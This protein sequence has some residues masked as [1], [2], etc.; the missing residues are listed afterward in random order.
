MALPILYLP[1][2][3]GKQLQLGHPWLY[4]DRLSRGLNYPS[5]T[6]VQVQSGRVQ[7]YGLWDAESPIAVRV[8]SLQGVPDRA[9]VAQRISEAWDIR[10]PV[11]AANT[12]AY[13]WV[14]G[15][16]DGLPGIVVDLY[17]DYAVIETFAESLNTLLDWV[18][19]GL[20]ACASLK[21]ILVRAEAV[22]VLSGR[23]PPRDLIVEENGLRFYADL[24]AGQKTGLYLDHRDNRQYLEGWCAGK[25]VLNCF[26]YTGAFTLYA[27]RGGAAQ[28][29]SADIAPQA[30]EEARR[31]LAL[32]GFPVEAH[33]C[34]VADCFDLLQAYVESGE[35][36]DL[37]VLD[38]P[39]LARSR[40][41][42]HAA[43]RAYARLNQS[44]MRC[45]PAGGLLATASCT[46][47]VSPQA[48]LDV[49]GDA[50]ARA[51]KRLVVLHEA[52]QA[53]DHPV[54]AQF[55]EGR[56]LKFVLGRVQHRV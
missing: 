9:W 27:V 20:R 25:R 50:A 8:F 39:S 31:N 17:N 46:S 54:P 28:V 41:S 19:E 35:S 44:A 7:G 21:G 48:F 4:R 42:R 22:H 52:A 49:L 29:I 56:Y 1:A 3:L 18:A 16:G 12:T 38:P 53:L 5:G 34:I 15:E 24:F 32:N 10:A 33:P 40:K 14:Y 36:F 30:V 51:G 37:I 45:L 2:E 23:R 43:L 47:Q 26:A 55:P 6:W 11:R 13:R